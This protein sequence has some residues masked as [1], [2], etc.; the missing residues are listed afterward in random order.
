M[1]SVLLSHDSSTRWILAAFLQSSYVS[2]SDYLVQAAFQAATRFYSGK[3]P[4]LNRA[5]PL[6]KRSKRTEGVGE[7]QR[8]MKTALTCA[9]LATMIS[10]TSAWLL[11]RFSM[12]ALLLFMPSTARSPQVKESERSCA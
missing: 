8:K 9:A 6:A 4:S 5:K 12:A 1:W 3:V 11:A 2:A 7:K 10:F